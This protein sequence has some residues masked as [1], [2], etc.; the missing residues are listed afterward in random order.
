MSEPTDHADAGF[1]RLL[2]R[3]KFSAS[4]IQ[5]GLWDLATITATE[6]A[7]ARRAAPPHSDHHRIATSSGP[8]PASIGAPPQSPVR[9]S[10]CQVDMLLLIYAHLSIPSTASRAARRSCGGCRSVLARQWR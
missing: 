7:V 9:S 5:H 2:E 10:M 6:G 4:R 3:A 1:R 8:R